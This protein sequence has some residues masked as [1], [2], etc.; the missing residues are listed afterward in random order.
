MKKKFYKNKF[1]KFKLIKLYLLK[2]NIMENKET[3]QE[4]PSK[5]QMIKWME[6]QIEFKKVQLELQ[7]IDTEIAVHRAEY[8]KA[9][10]TIAQISSPQEDKS[11]KE[12]TLT[13]DDIK[14]NPE[15]EEQGFKVGDVVGV[16]VEE[17]VTEEAPKMSMSRRGL[18]KN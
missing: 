6:E 4:T 10:Y 17:P 5:D 9:M 15:L 11:M 8:M 13:E 14:A 3:T 18:K 7:K 2:N 1:G 16:P 12:H